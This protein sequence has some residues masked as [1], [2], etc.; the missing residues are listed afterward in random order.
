MASFDKC[1]FFDRFPYFFKTTNLSMMQSI[2]LFKI[3]QHSVVVLVFSVIYQSIFAKLLYCIV[4][5]ILLRVFLSLLEKAVKPTL[6]SLWAFTG[7]F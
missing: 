2:S 3:F 1:F 6:T 5:K 7:I 4:R